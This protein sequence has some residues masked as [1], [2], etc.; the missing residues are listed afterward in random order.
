MLRYVIAFCAGLVVGWN[1]LPQP[2]WVADLYKQVHAKF[3]DNDTGG[4]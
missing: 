2:P 3:I 4:K 1:A